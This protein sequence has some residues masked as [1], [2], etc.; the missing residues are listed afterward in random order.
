[1]LQRNTPSILKFLEIYLAHL[2]GVCRRRSLLGLF[3]E[4]DTEPEHY[5]T[6]CD[7]CLSRDQYTVKNMKN[8]L[9]VVINALDQL[10]SRGEVKIAEWIWGSKLAWTNEF[11]I[12]VS[13]HMEIIVEELLSFGGTFCGSAMLMD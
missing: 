1:M 2:S 13:C 3:G 4:T 5:G 10:G 6:C 7:V 12:K 9:A 11:D 8:E